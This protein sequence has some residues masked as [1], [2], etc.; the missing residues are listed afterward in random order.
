[1][2]EEDCKQACASLRISRRGVFKE[3]RPCY[4][5]GNGVCNQNIK[6][7]GNK[8]TRICQGIQVQNRL[9]TSCVGKYKVS[10]SIKYLLLCYYHKGHHESQK[11]VDNSLNM[12]NT[13]DVSPF[14]E[15][16]HVRGNMNANRITNFYKINNIL[17]IVLEIIL[18]YS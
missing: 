7:P 13:H 14:H 4:K 6:R 18:Y 11:Y 15:A 3:G 12:V 10:Y 9:V 1:M 17:I 5:S 16:L 2:N 8:A